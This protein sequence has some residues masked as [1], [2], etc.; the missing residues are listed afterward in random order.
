MRMF[1]A[2]C[3]FAVLPGLSGFHFKFGVILRAFGFQ[4]GVECSFFILQRVL[5]D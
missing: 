5:Q 2:F 4:I 3:K 1:S